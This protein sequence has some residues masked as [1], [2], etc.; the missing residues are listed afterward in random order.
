MKLS[1]ELPGRTRGLQS[2]RLR[3]HDATTGREALRYDRAG[4]DDAAGPDPYTRKN[5]RVSPDPTSGSDLDSGS[6]AIH[7]VADRV[8]HLVDVMVGPDQRHERTQ[9]AVVA[10]HN[11]AFAGPNVGELADGDLSSEA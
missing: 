8:A 10:D 4:T 5:H 7:S 9:Q 11:R 3:A 2:S 1:Y 6:R